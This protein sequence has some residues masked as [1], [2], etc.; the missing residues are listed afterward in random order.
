MLFDEAQTTLV[1]F[2]GGL[3][4]SYAVPSTVTNIESLAFNDCINLAAITVDPSSPFYSSVGGV[5]FDKTQATLLQFPGG[6]GG[7]YSIPAGVITIGDGAFQNCFHLTG[8]TIPNSVTTL[9]VNSFQGCIGLTSVVVPGSVVAIETGAFYECSHL[10]NV[11]LSNG[12]ASIGD[13][14]FASCILHPVII[15]GSVTNIGN[16]AFLSSGFAGSL[17]IPGSV[18]S[19]GDDA[20]YDTGLLSITISNGVTSIGDSAFA[21]CRY[22]SSITIPD[23]VVSMGSFAF[24]GC[25]MLQHVILGKGLVNIGRDEFEYDD[26][27]TL[28]IP[29]SVTNI[30]DG[31]FEDTGAKTIYF[32][33]NAPTNSIG[34]FQGFIGSVFYLPGTKGWNSSNLL[35]NP[36]LWNP[37]CANMGVRTNQFGFTINATNLNGQGLAIV[38][39]TNLA[40]PVW[41]QVAFRTI[42]GN[43]AY[44]SDSQ[45]TNYPVRYY[46][47]ASPIAP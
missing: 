16:N 41:T 26:L 42:S 7:S 23:S 36:A 18:I 29:A 22:L 14:A 11:T 45:W 12:V 1:Q 43:S 17:I 5:L 8:V 25:S 38:A 35:I 33:G 13:S 34:A 24:E 37:Q 27:A 6:M 3:G 10:A 28:V 39:T 32:A 15:P 21:Y 30:Q 31:A 47:I 44:F 19:I 20:F 46:R 2:P 9:G 40:N 4:G